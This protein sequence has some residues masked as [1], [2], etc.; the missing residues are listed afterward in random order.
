LFPILLDV[1]NDEL[2]PARLPAND[3]LE[4]QKISPDRPQSTSQETPYTAVHDDEA[5]D[6]NDGSYMSS[7][8]A[9]PRNQL[10]RSELTA[11]ARFKTL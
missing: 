9:P 5:E 1:D 4:A 3:D 6:G 10:S 11:A 8:M 2:G 7:F